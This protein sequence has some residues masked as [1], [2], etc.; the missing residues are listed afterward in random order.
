VAER[1]GTVGVPELSLFCLWLSTGKALTPVH[2][3]EGINP[4][5]ER[6]MNRMV[7]KGSSHYGYNH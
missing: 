3:I 6:E 4:E 2:M 1:R 7:S 5:H